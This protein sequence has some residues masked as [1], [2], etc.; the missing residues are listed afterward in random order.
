MVFSNIIYDL[1]TS[2]ISLI[3]PRGDFNGDVIYGDRNYDLAKLAQCIV[4]DYDYIVSNLFKLD[5][6]DHQVNYSIYNSRSDEEK[7]Y[8]VKNICDRFNVKE[9]SVLLLTAIQFLTMIPL[10][11][12]N[13]LH[14]K[15]M[16]TKFVEL[17][18]KSYEVSL[19]ENN[20]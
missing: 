13:E 14:Q 19:E 16:Y 5:Y 12:E 10:H 17:L 18:N 7:Y 20:A 11:Y 8:L 2:S 6:N 4:G 3:D 1:N 9:S 15:L